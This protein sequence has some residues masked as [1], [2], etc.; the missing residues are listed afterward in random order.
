[1]N[2]N[3]KKNI[4]KSIRS[5]KRSVSDLKLILNANYSKVFYK[6]TSWFYSYQKLKKVYGRINLKC[7]NQNRPLESKFWFFVYWTNISN[8]YL[9]KILYICTTSPLANPRFPIAILKVFMSFVKLLLVLLKENTKW[10]IS[11]I[12]KLIK[13]KTG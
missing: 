11:F 4:L 2:I 7:K 9:Y 13:N 12:L 8:N 5:L 1:M 10:F 6:P 3:N